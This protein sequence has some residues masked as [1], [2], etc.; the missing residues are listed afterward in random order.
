[1]PTAI[2]HAPVPSSLEVSKSFVPVSDALSQSE[3]LAEGLAQS[4]P[5]P[6]SFSDS[7]THISPSPDEPP[8]SLLNTETLGGV[9]FTQEE[10][11]L[12]QEGTLQPLNG[13]ELHQEGE[14]SDLSPRTTDLGKQAGMNNKTAQHF[15][16][17]W[18]I[19][20]FNKLCYKRLCHH[21]IKLCSL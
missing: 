1:M 9:E 18:V 4:S 7:Y 2:T 14:E 17:V 5:D 21:Y 6:D 11:K 20:Y 15:T 19:L 12:A 13:E 3:G 16:L 10:E 8:A